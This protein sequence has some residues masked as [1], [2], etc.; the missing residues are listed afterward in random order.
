MAAQNVWGDNIVEDEGD[1]V[2][3]EQ[4]APEPAK[5]E[6]SSTK[7][8]V[9]PA[10][11]APIRVPASMASPLINQTGA[12]VGPLPEQLHPK[13]VGQEDGETEPEAPG[14]ELFEQARAALADPPQDLVKAT[15][16]VQ[17]IDGLRTP[18]KALHHEKMRLRHDASMHLHQLQQGPVAPVFNGN[19]LAEQIAAH[20]PTRLR[21]RRINQ[22]KELAAKH[23]EVANHPEI[24]AY[25]EQHGK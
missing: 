8:A 22:I 3:G 5:V 15:E 19:H 21:E 14:G 4:P 7:P 6:A 20:H 17:F 9:R 23:P 2:Q 18:T 13:H 1:E 25:L 16:L 12:G 10:R 11:P 24:K